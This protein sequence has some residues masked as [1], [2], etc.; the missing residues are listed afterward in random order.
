[1]AS[2]SSH[3]W[4]YCGVHCPTPQQIAQRTWQAH[5]REVKNVGGIIIPFEAPSPNSASPLVQLYQKTLTANHQLAI[6]GFEPGTK[7]SVGCEKAS[8]TSQKVSRTAQRVL[9]R[10]DE[11]NIAQLHNIIPVCTCFLCEL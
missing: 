5:S 6:F 11:L 9:P 1:M 2:S 8:E 3:S 7:Q 4:C 10:E